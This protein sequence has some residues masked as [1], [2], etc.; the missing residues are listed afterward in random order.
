MDNTIIDFIRIPV[1]KNG[2]MLYDIKT[3]K[4]LFNEYLEKTGLSEEDYQK[5]ATAYAQGNSKNELILEAL[6]N[7]LGL[8][9]DS[10]EYE[11]EYNSL[12]ER[13]GMTEEEIVEIYGDKTFRN[14]VFYNLAVKVLVDKGEYESQ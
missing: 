13:M 7:N 10:T 9:E 6:V 2:E 1:D 12:L 3:V 4:N 11:E 14:T 8:N 5:A